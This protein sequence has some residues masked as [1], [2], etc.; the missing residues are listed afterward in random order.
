MNKIGEVLT[1]KIGPLPAWGWGVIVV[2]GVVFYL[3]YRASQSG[4]SAA[5]ANTA[6]VP[7]GTN[8]QGTTAA[9]Y[10]PTLGDQIGALT[11]D[12]SALQGL[13]TQLGLGPTG[14]GTPTA[15]GTPPPSVSPQSTS[16]LPPGKFLGL[17]GVLYDSSGFW[18]VNGIPYPKWQFSS[19]PAPG[20]AGSV[21]FAIPPAGWPFQP[22]PGMDNSTPSNSSGGL[23]SG[24]NPAP[25][26][27]S[28]TSASIPSATPSLGFPAATTQRVPA[29]VPGVGG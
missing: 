4:T 7:F 26:Q 22:V 21:G 3:R 2:A 5:T 15:S 12:I 1:K 17:D 27:P 28:Q 8:G 14:Q 10:S 25:V 16:S 9:G 11:G 20:S 29:H 18:W 13:N 19:P 23:L 6:S 24:G